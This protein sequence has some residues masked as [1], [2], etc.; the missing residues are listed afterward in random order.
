MQLKFDNKKDLWHLFATPLGMFNLD[1]SKDYT[2]KIAEVILAREKAEGGIKRSNK[3]GWHSNEEM[4]K[5]PELEFADLENLFRS[6]VYKMIA[7]TSLTKK[8]KSKIEITAWA[9]VNRKG[10]FNSNHIHPTNHWSGVFYIQAED[11]SKDPVK[12]AGFLEFQDPRGAI[13]MLINPSSQ[14]DKVGFQPKVGNIMIFPSWLY[15]GVNPFNIDSVRISI[16]FN[17]KI[18]QFVAVED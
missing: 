3:G 13:T 5:W 1:D 8:F 18:E 12:R 7:S 11:F 16:A 10:S 17:A 9:N 2:A 15:H 14:P 4:L 6:V